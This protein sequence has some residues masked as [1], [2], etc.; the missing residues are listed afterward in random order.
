[1][2]YFGILQ[3]IWD[4]LVSDELSPGGKISSIALF[5]FKEGFTKLSRLRLSY[6][7]SLILPATWP[8]S[9]RSD[10]SGRFFSCH[11][12]DVAGCS[13]TPPHARIWSTAHSANSFSLGRGLAKCLSLP[14]A[15]Q[16]G[17]ATIGSPPGKVRALRSMSYTSQP[18][19]ALYMLSFRA[20]NMATSFFNLRGLFWL[21]PI[22][23]FLDLVLD[24][25][26]F[27]V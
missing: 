11:R 1:M 21:L 10:P 22:F 17:C 19:S 27:S 14:H 18:G 23:D 5:A 26:Y 3:F 25:W 9:S 16:G 24:F 15:R 13:K 12:V 7:F 20:N 8:H 4:Y 2:D 6:N